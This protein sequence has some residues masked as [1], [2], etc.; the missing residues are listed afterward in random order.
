MK[1]ARIIYEWPPPWL[2]LA[3]A[4]YEMTTAQIK[5]GHEFEVF[6][7]RWPKAGP[8]E[9][10][11]N[12]KLF[13]VW[14]A[15]LQGT[16]ALTSSIVILF[17]YLFQRSKVKHDLIHAHG[18]F[19]LWIYAYRFLLEKYFPWAKELETPL[20]VQFH[21]T[22]AGRRIKLEQDNKSIKVVSQ[23]ID[24]PLAELS[25]RLAIKIADAYVFVSEDLKKE[26]IEHYSADPDKCFVIETGVNTRNFYY[27]GPEETA[28]TRIEMGL[29]AA[30]KIILN[31]GAMVERKNIHLLV[32]SLEFL[33]K[34]YKLVL[35]GSGDEE[36]MDKI[37]AT[38][39]TK[40]LKERVIKIGYTPYPQV[41]IAYQ[42]ADLFVL[43]SSFEGLPKVAMESLACGTQVL[44][45]GFKIE[46][47]IMGIEYLDNIEAK[48]MAEKIKDMIQN[49]RKVDIY[50]VGKYYSW[51]VQALVLENVY[52]KAKENHQ[53]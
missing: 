38:I 30:D 29:E 42:A 18:H 13:P 53:K 8:I 7:G 36:Y 2:G 44:A 10:V 28:K 14:R 24:W 51:D 23:Y 39:V 40:H 19:G 49:P 20:V 16:I 3:P 43:P 1:I 41:P 37:N 4:P 11:K 9:L 32:E 6:C 5:L 34:N 48:Y 33:P 31:I 45:S 21:N 17:R 25:D 50:T 22:V 47:E 52:A 15:P 27:V 26:A 12:V 35:M 46:K